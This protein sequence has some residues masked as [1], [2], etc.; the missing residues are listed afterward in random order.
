MRVLSIFRRIKSAITGAAAN[1]RLRQLVIGAC[2]AAGVFAAY[3]RGLGVMEILEYKSLDLRFKI[4]GPIPQTLPIV[5]VN[6]DQD[7]FDELDLPFPWPRTLHA[8]LIRKLKAAGAKVIA[9]DV[10]FTEPKA[11]PHED[12]ALAAAIRDAGNVV[13]AAEHT[14]VDSDFG[15][16]TRLSLPIPLIRQYARA[17]GPA[18]LVFDAD[19]VVRGGRFAIPFQERNYP[20]LAYR[21]YEAATGRKPSTGNDL[22][23]GRYIINYRGPNRSYPLVPYYRIL[24]DEIDPALFRDKIVFVGAYAASLHDIFPTPFNASDQM[25]G[26]EI[27][28]NFVDTLAGNNP[29]VLVPGWMLFTLFIV[30][31]AITI[32]ASIHLKPLEATT[33]VIVSIGVYMFLALYLFS[34]NNLWLGVAPVFLACTLSYGGIVLDHYIAERKERLFIRAT[35]G[36]YVSHDIVEEILKSPETMG[37]EGKRKHIT[38]L[39][40][41]VRGFTA[42]S[43]QI[44]PEQVV[45]LLSDYLGRVARIVFEHKGT[46][47]KF[48]GD[49]VFAV[50]GAPVSHGDDA[51]RAIQTGIAMIELVDSLADR[52]KE[53]IGRPLKVGIGINSGDA[54]VGN[55]GSEVRYDYTCI[56]DTVNLGARLEALTKELGVPMLVSEFTAA[57]LNGAIPLR[58]LRRVKVQGREAP[59][60][61]YCPEA[62]IKG[63]IET[64]ADVETPYVQQHK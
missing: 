25:A 17:Y 30:F 36:K 38:V 24:R 9:F 57:E 41:D 1:K 27:Q 63:E 49:A 46:V 6:I 60:M 56:G 3:E 26:V 35:F 4:R 28:A 52:W 13:L 11:D 53:V 19:G 34:Y 62:L 55:I 37:L 47:D 29:I 10:L 61:V 32:W 50:F 12:Q 21:I 15:L 51:A 31:V 33:A 64:P 14:Q 18:N 5:I 39:F 59:I 44:T 23:T 16:R 22:S 40:S 45:S 8:E 43:E 2:L 7:S 54:V 58:P 48:I 42:L 20:A